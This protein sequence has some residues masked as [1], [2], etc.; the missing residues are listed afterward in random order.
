MRTGLSRII[1]TAR[2]FDFSTPLAPSPSMVLGASEVIPLELARAYCAFASGGVLPVPFTLKKVIDENGAVLALRHMSA[3]RI[4][5][6]DK[7]YI[8]NSLLRSVVT[9]GTA[10]GLAGRG[11]TVPAAGKTGTTNDSRDAWFVGYTP[12]LLALVW[13]GFDDGDS[14]RNTGATAALPIW[15][16]LVR[17]VPQCM[18]GSWFTMPEGVITKTICKES[19]QLAREGCCPLQLDEVFLAARVPSEICTLHQAGPISGVIEKIKNFLNP[20]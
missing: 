9:E 5:P 13:V 12:D 10:R 2:Q 19:G 7:A 18:S 15:A 14:I 6:Q 11:I 3:K 8:M 17:S 16:E 1:L 20:F 4:I